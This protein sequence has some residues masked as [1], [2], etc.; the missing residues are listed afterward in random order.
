[1]APDCII[2]VPYLFRV[3]TISMWGELK[4][5]PMTRTTLKVKLIQKISLLAN[6][7]RTFHLTDRSLSP[8]GEQICRTSSGLLDSVSK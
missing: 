2:F 4:R 6:D 5:I 1:M 7:V 3:S 8:T